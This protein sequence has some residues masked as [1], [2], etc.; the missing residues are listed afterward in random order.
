MSCCRGH[1]TGLSC[2][3]ASSHSI[4]QQNKQTDR[5]KSPIK[6][7]N[8]QTKIFMATCLTLCLTIDLQRPLHWSQLFPGKLTFNQATKQADKFN[9]ATK[10][11]KWFN[12]ATKQTNRQTN[13]NHERA[14]PHNRSNTAEATDST[15]LF[16][17]KLINWSIKARRKERKKQKTKKAKK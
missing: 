5:Q 6:Q 12:P 4:K 9:Q 14:Q 1:C 2:F 15:Q 7:Q 11:K 3:Q 17:S 10:Q 8:K 13:K 16:P